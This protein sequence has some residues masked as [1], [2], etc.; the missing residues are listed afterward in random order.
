MR[1]PH[2]PFQIVFPRKPF[3]ALRARSLARRLEAVEDLRTFVDIV[4]VA[5]QVFSCSEVSRTMRTSL[6]SVVVSTMPAEDVSQAQ[7]YI[8]QVV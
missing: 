8:I 4:D 5:I 1:I 2:M 6:W 7:E 3:P